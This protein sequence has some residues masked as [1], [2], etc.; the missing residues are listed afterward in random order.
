LQVVGDV[1]VVEWTEE[2]SVAEVVE[3]EVAEALAEEEWIEVDGDVV[4]LCVV[5][6]ELLFMCPSRLFQ[7]PLALRTCCLILCFYYSDRGR[8]RPKP[9]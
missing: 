2:V 1:E 5:E 4:V 8:D 9:Y 6:G 3:T 7:C